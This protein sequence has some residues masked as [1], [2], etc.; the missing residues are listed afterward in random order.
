MKA[1]PSTA[2]ID[3]RLQAGN[4]SVLENEQWFPR[5]HGAFDVEAPLG[6]TDDAW[7]SLVAQDTDVT[8]TWLLAE[9][10]AV[11][12][13]PPRGGRGMPTR[14]R[15]LC[16]WNVADGTLAHASKISQHDSGVLDARSAHD[17]LLWLSAGEVESGD[18][19]ELRLLVPPDFRECFRQLFDSASANTYLSAQRIAPLRAPTH[20]V[21][22]LEPEALPSIQ[23]SSAPLKCARCRSSPTDP[24]ELMPA[25]GRSP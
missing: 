18:V 13:D 12:A 14:R 9:V 10:Y 1:Q 7:A 16:V 8:G 24:S 3:E 21:V 4:S 22:N 15:F 17:R 6:W 20:W 19:Y 5:A 23:P 11:S 2:R 25:S